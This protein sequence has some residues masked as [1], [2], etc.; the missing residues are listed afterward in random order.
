ML[1]TSRLRAAMFSLIA[2][3][4]SCWAAAAMWFAW[5]WAVALLLCVPVGLA[6]DYA[7]LNQA[8]NV[9]LGSLYGWALLIVFGLLGVDAIRRNRGRPKPNRG[10]DRT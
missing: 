10:R 1:S 5:E 3:Q 4:S 9:L 6:F 2:A 7:T 8:A